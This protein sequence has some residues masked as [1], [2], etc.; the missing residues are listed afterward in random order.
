MSVYIFGI[1]GQGP[2]S[3]SSSSTSATATSSGA[4]AS[5]TSGW[6]YQGCYSDAG[7]ARTLGNAING[8]GTTMTN[9]LCQSKCKAAGYTLA[10]TEYS[11]EC[12]RFIVEI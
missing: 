7:G 9:E 6:T 11:G 10:G 3:T 12:C 5:S 4:A 1:P 8:F 2:A